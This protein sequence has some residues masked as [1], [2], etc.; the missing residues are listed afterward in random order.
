MPAIARLNDQIGHIITT[1]TD[2]GP[3]TGIMTTGMITTVTQALVS[4]DMLYAACV[5][6]TVIC[7][8]HPN[9]APNLIVSGSSKVSFTLNK[10]APARTGDATTC[11]AMIISGSTTTSVS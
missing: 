1:Q 5:G 2:N 10:L 8:M 3:V 9:I 11:G 4:V 6:D 7:S